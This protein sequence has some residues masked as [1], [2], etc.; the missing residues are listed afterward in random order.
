MELNEIYKKFNKENISINESLELY[1]K[2]NKRGE[3]LFNQLL[4]KNNLNLKT[5]ILGDIPLE[6]LY[7]LDMYERSAISIFL[8]NK[9]GIEMY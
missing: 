1:S 7:E 8:E 3:K 4:L 6:S 2:I 9:D 5:S